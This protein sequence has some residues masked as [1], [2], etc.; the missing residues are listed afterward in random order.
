MNPGKGESVIIVGGGLIGLSIG[1]RLAEAGCAVRILER[2]Q[3]GRGASWAAA[4]MLAAS[5][6]TEPGLEAL[7]PPGR[8]AQRLWP[9]FASDLE[10]VSGEAIGY[11]P[12]PTLFVEPDPSERGRLEARAEFLSGLGAEVEL[13]GSAALA[14]LE[15][16]LGVPNA[17]ALVSH[18]D[19]QA[20]NRRA[21][22]ALVRAF[23]AAG[24]ILEEGV[25]VRRM[26]PERA[27]WRVHTSE[28][29][30]EARWA[31]LAAGPWAAGPEIEG[32]ANVPVGPL[33][34][35]IVAL[36]APTGAPVLRNV[37]WGPGIYL[38][39]RPGGRLLLGA[40]VEEAG[41]DARVTASGV[42]GL[43]A[44]ARRVLPACADYEI[45]EMWA[46]F[47][48]V[49]PDPLPI[50]GPAGPPGLI[51]AVAHHRNGVLL[52]PLTAELIKGYVLTGA[53]PDGYASLAPERIGMLAG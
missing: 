3:A 18:E 11:V 6:E 51:L 13:L 47:R 16:A 37:V 50:V 24:G 39:P 10:R 46:G 40:T 1:W 32:L 53:W 35:Q 21:V 42:G 49:G 31:V 9:A 4:G 28:G 30:R 25:T 22:V 52:A 33:K 48:P 45:S 44:N 27:G 17:G 41:F 7:F 38:V 8:A 2:G 19:G 43:I 15:P 14:A 23:K 29:S 26:V 34:G 5:I 20:D 12:G 36:E